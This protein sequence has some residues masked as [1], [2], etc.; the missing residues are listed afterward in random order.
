MAGGRTGRAGFWARLAG[1][2]DPRKGLSGFALLGFFLLSLMATGLGFADLR[3][4]NTDAEQLSAPELAFTIATTLFVVSAM[5]VA[6][7]AAITD[8]RIV[9]KLL[10]LVFYLLFAVWSVG[11]GYGFFWKEFA[12]KEFTQAQFGRVIDGISISLDR[13][14]GALETAEQATRSAADL[15]RRRAESEAR[16]GRT[17]ANHPA[18]TPGEGPLMRARF[19]FSEGAAALARDVDQKWIAPLAARR[20]QLVRRVEALKTRQL[21]ED[22]DA[23]PAEERALLAKLASARDLPSHERRVLFVGVHAEAEAFAQASNSLRQLNAAAFAERLSLLAA[24]VGPDPRNPGSADPARA[25]DPGYC[26]DVVLNQQMGQAAASLRAIGDVETPAFEF[27]EGAKA[28]RAAFFG[29]LTLV[30]GLFGIAAPAGAAIPFGQKEFLALF[31]SLAVD[32]GIL[33]LTLVRD[34]PE[35]K[36]KPPKKGRPAKGAGDPRPPQLS[37]ILGD[38]D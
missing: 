28:T 6:L 34:L 27:L 20:A 1:L 18:S 11:F 9:I 5:V 38:E 3:A 22:A 24:D 21:P 7:H 33:F 17:C 29:L 8:R 2:F 26:W 35:P 36:Q 31:A 14:A 37:S 19:A 32:L 10:S 15:A 25:A 12:G 30:A 23:L 4:A 13:T 16:D